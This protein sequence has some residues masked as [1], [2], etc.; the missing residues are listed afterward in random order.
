MSIP[1]TRHSPDILKEVDT[2]DQRQM[3]MGGTVS[4]PAI[5]EKQTSCDHNWERDGQTMTAMR[6][7]CTKCIKTELR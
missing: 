7:T 5:L 2:G 4:T 1:D 3:I 6:W